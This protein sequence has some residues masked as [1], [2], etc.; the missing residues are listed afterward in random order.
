MGVTLMSEVTVEKR[1]D[2]WEEVTGKKCDFCGDV[3]VE[4]I[5]DWLM[6][7]YTRTSFVTSDGDR[8]KLLVGHV[9]R[10]CRERDPDPNYPKGVQGGADDGE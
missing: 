9:C 7:V 2:R 8:R 1:V 6:P 4:D 3:F 10:A 5:D